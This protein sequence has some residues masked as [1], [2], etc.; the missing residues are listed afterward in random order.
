MRVLDFAKTV[1]DAFILQIIRQISRGFF[2]NG[3]SILIS[4]RFNFL[5]KILLMKLISL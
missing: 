1:G 3:S 2:L 5:N 4:K